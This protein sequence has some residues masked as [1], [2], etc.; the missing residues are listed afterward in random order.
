MVY[1]FITKSDP[2]IE[3]LLEKVEGRMK[4]LSYWPSK[5]RSIKGY[6]IYSFTAYFLLQTVFLMIMNWQRWD[7]GFKVLSVE[8]LN[9]LNGVM[10][11]A[12]DAFINTRRTTLFF[13]IMSK[14]YHTY[15]V[16]STNKTNMKTKKLQE[17]FET[18]RKSIVK[19][20]EGRG[21]FLVSFSENILNGYYASQILSPLFGIIFFFLGYAR[22]DR[23]SP[24]FVFYFPGITSTQYPDIRSISNFILICLVEFLQIAYASWLTFLLFSCLVITV[25]NIVVEM[26]L[27]EINLEE[28]N[29]FYGEKS[30]ELARSGENCELQ[31]DISGTSRCFQGNFDDKVSYHA[32][33]KHCIRNMAIHHQTIYKKIRM[34]NTMFS[35]SMFYANTFICFQL[36]FA[37]FCFQ[38]GDLVFKIKYGLLLVSMLMLQYAYSENGQMVKDEVEKVRLALNECEWEGHPSWFYPYFQMMLIQSS[39]QPKLNVFNIFTMDRK[40]MASVVQAA[41]SYFNLLS[42]LTK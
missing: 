5:K 42:R 27:F 18:M 4:V 26:K 33:L 19:D 38:I 31:N 7:F 15:Q 3:V 10:S 40:N 2:G 12:T 23:L 39:I 28:F 30:A 8:N 36:C 22:L 34:L 11:L 29:A 21:I 32:C 24:P 41:Y 14:R 25:N 37:I 1:M 13:E 16:Y 6:L 17:K 9:Y 20:M 35:Y